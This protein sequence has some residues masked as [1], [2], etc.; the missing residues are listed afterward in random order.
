MPEA[1]SPAAEPP[2]SLGE[3]I[4][5]KLATPPEAVADPAAAAVT[6][7]AEASTPRSI[8]DRAREAGF[9]NVADENEAVERLFQA[10]QDRE[11]LAQEAAERAQQFEQLALLRAQQP[12]QPTPAAATAAQT[13]AANDKWWNPPPVDEVAMNFY[14]NPDGKTFKEGTPV[15]I[16]QQ[17]ERFEAYQREW[18]AKLLRRPDEALQP[19]I[20]EIVK[21]M[22]AQ[23]RQSLESKSEEEAVRTRF[24][25]NATW[26]Y[27]IDPVT[28]QPRVDTRN[29][30]FMLSPDGAKF[31]EFM[32]RA[33]GMGIQSLAGQLEY[34]EAMRELE[35]RRTQDGQT[36]AAQQAA[37]VN[38]QS[39]QDLLKRALPGPSQA[40]TFATPTERR[41][42][43]Q[44]QSLGE[45][46]LAEM[47]RTGVF[48]P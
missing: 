37:Q 4:A 16:R 8:L 7:P 40:G 13:S 30:G 32:D 33:A 14:L 28:K 48:A 23:E 5:A 2:K 34:A 12:Q 25:A 9:E 21:E 38:A 20:K 11:R 18:A 29:G 17:A 47:Q 46:V 36:A 43:N 45:K 42:Q 10:L 19:A 15:E 6:P 1:I 26:L 31:G 44:R 24:L 35:N 27:Q 22:L 41:T 3:A 39:K